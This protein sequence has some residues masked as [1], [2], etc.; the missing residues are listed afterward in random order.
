[1]LTKKKLIIYALD[2]RCTHN[3]KS[4]TKFSCFAFSDIECVNL[5]KTHDADPSGVGTR[6]C[7]LAVFLKLNQSATY[8]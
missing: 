1:M 5:D 3:L 8:E 4:L 7:S 2:T 6:T